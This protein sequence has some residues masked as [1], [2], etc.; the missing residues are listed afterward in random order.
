MK[1]GPIDV[2]KYAESFGAKGFAIE[3]PDRL[4]PV[5]EKALRLDGP[6]LISVPLDYRE[7]HKLMD[8]VHPKALN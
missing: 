6:V 4:A 1:F 7:N 3:A 5:L 8:V 2:V